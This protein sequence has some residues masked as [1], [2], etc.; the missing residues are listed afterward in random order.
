MKN[1]SAPNIFQG[2]GERRS[3][4]KAFGQKGIFSAKISLHCRCPFGRKICAL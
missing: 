3:T 2:L 4:L 1:E